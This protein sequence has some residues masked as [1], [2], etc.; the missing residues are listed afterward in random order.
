M[1]SADVGVFAEEGPEAQLGIQ[2]GGRDG[3]AEGEIRVLQ[4]VRLVA[5][6]KGVGRQRRL[7]LKRGVVADLDE[8]AVGRDQFGQGR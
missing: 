5:V 3:Q 6:I 4:E 8:F 1:P 2:V 7:A